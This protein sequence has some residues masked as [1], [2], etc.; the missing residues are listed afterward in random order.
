MFRGEAHVFRLDQWRAK[1]SSPEEMNRLSLHAAAYEKLLKDSADEKKPSI[2]CFPSV[3][4]ALSWIDQQQLSKLSVLVTGS[5]YLVGAFLK[6][7]QERSHDE[8]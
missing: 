8:T 5:L 3:S 1:Q 7:C 4:H 6:V 2:H